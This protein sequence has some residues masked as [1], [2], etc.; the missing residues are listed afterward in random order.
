[1]NLAT[2]VGDAHFLAQMLQHRLQPR[3][4]AE[5]SQQLDL[6]LERQADQPGNVVGQLPGRVAGAGHGHDLLVGLA[7]QLDVLLQVGDGLQLQRF[8]NGVFLGQFFVAGDDVGIEPL[9]ADEAHAAV[10]LDEHLDADRR[11]QHVARRGQD[12]DGEDVFGA[13]R[14]DFGITLDNNQ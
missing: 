10:Q 2:D 14:L 7:H 1:M 13:G 6:G 4:A 8:V 12:G 5:V 11:A 3:P 9:Q